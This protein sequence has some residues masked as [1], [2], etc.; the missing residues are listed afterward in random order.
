MTL[1]NMVELVQQVVPDLGDP[2]IT[3][4][5]NQAYRTFCSE[6]KYLRGTVNVNLVAGTFIYALPDAVEAM[7]S[8]D[9]LG[10]DGAELHHHVSYTLKDRFISLTDCRGE[11]LTLLPDGAA[12][13]RFSGILIPAEMTAF[14]AS[15]LVPV[16]FHSALVSKAIEGYAVTRGN[17]PLAQYHMAA[18]KLGLH[19][20][21]ILAAH[22]GDD[23][24]YQPTIA[25][26]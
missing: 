25:T 11:L 10:A 5:L 6:S 19:D 13:I 17:M 16:Q 14:T 1:Q 12:V 21:K 4:A 23:T 20:A 8:L 24:A 26:Y 9:I 2:F 3:L 18:Y 7:T 22:G 15:P